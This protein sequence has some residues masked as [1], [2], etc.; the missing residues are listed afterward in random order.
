[1]TRFREAFVTGASS[2]I[3]RAVSLE[4]ARRGAFVHVFARRA[5][6]L[7]A[8]VDEIRAEGGDAHALPG[9]VTDLA[10]VTR[11][12]DEA[13]ARTESGLDLVLAG[14]GVAES[15]VRDAD[16][17][18]TA[19]TVFEVN[20][21]GAAAT[22]EAGIRV[23]RPRGHGTVAVLSSLA[24]AR[25]LPG[26][27]AYCASKSAISAYS[28]STRIDLRGTG[29]AVVDVRP[30]FVRTP[31]TAPNRFPMPFLMDADSA[32]RRALDGIERGCAVV[33]FP[34]RLAWP[35][36]LAARILPGPAWRRLVGGKT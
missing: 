11:A 17:T 6:D 1:M 31:M 7:D 16:P 36:E 5:H 9:D 32:A 33:R 19:H 23:M 8:L 24:A 12:V 3:G 10:S 28:E 25:G 29:I 27:A 30:G 15:S 20:L 35:L 2:G 4:L 34:R 21:T 13:D 22:L 18:R 26:A 14:A